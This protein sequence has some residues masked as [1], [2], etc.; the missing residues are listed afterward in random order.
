[1][2]LP[3]TFAFAS[4]YR[5]TIMLFSKLLAV[6]AVTTFFLTGCDDRTAEEKQPSL[7]KLFPPTETYPKGYTDVQIGYYR[8]RAPSE[9]A[10]VSVNGHISLYRSWPE[11]ENTKGILTRS[12]SVQDQIDTI[13]IFIDAPR[14]SFKA[15]NFAEQGTAARQRKIEVFGWIKDTES[16][17]KR[18]PAFWEYRSSPKSV[19]NQFRPI[20]AELLDPLGVPV[21]FRCNMHPKIIDWDGA[22]NTYSPMLP[23]CNVGVYWPDGHSMRIRFSRKHMQDA[24]KIYQKVMELHDSM[25]LQ[26]EQDQ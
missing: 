6:L 11:F 5:E 14:R 26:S 12:S 18:Y 2:Q 10:N 24:V 4:D 8:L 25:I 17:S 16:E 15:G 23:K 7:V 3:A 19:A 21:M 22:K 20:K 1:M 13:N 9:T